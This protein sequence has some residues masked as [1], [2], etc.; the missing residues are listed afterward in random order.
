MKITIEQDG[1]EPKVIETVNFVIIADKGF[2]DYS[3]AFDWLMRE[4]NAIYEEVKQKRYL[5][6][7]REAIKKE[8]D[9]NSN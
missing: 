8:L 5:L 7:I 2:I 6:S 1:K 4:T 9:V 3:G